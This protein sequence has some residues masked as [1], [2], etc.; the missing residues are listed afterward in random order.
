MPSREAKRG[1]Q[2]LFTR[3]PRRELCELRLCRVL[4]S[5]ELPSARSDRRSATIRLRTSSC[6]YG[7]YCGSNKVIGTRQREKDEE[8]VRRM[9]FLF[10]ILVALM[11]GML[12]FMVDPSPGW[13]DTGVS[14]AMVLVASGLMGAIHPARAQVW[15]LAVRLWVPLMGFASDPA[16]FH[17]ASVLA[18]V[19]ATVGAYVGA[20]VGWFL[21]ESDPAR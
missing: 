3:V 10:L 4:G 5:S 19:F 6:G 20:Q 8:V 15:A 14:A 21:A 2:R 1:H 17:P 7:R 16:G 12:I 9:H 11:L 13:D 18:L